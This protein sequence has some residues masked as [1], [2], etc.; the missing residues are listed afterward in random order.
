MLKKNWGK[1]LY[2]YF[3]IFFLIYLEWG[4]EPV[5]AQNISGTVK[6][7]LMII[8]VLPL[9]FFENFKIKKNSILLFCYLTIIIILSALRDTEIGNSILLLVPIFC[10]FMLNS[11][12]KEDKIINTFCNNITFLAAYSL[13]VYIIAWIAP[14]IVTSFPILPNAYN[15][16]IHNL[17]LSV[18]PSG[19]SIIRN[20]GIAW[21]PGAFALL[22][23]LAIYGQIVGYS[24]LNKHKIIINIL[25]LITTFSTMGYAVFAIIMITTRFRTWSVASRSYSNKLLLLVVLGLTCLLLISYIEIYEVAFAKLSGFSFNEKNPETT[26]ARLNAIIYPGA[27]FLSSPLFGVGYDVFSIINKTVCNNVATNTIVNWFAIL[28]LAMGLP[29]IY[30]YI[31]AL[32]KPSNYLKLGFILKIILIAAFILL[33]STE[34][35]LRISLVYVII[36][37][38]CSAKNLT[39][40]A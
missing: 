6:T 34:S 7:I 3:I 29:C 36:F 37:Y 25:A 23:C 11:A 5:I 8:S 21:E 2:C 19:V 38:G 40:H 15:T 24:S 10:A 4:Y 27:A 39:K 20:Y 30:C 17:G 14:S 35:L 32:I 1:E 13:I 28:G 33:V 12:F 18:V 26:Q 16:P 22:L 9:C 31:N